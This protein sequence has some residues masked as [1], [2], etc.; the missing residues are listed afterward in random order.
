MKMRLEIDADAAYVYFKEIAD[1]EVDKTVS[2]NDAINIDIDKEG[3]ALGI[4][5]LEASKHLPKSA[6]TGANAAII[7]LGQ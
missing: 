6:L 4:E 3:R 5:I 7:A 2:L 1:G